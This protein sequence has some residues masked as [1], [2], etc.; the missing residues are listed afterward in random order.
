M[1]TEVQIIRLAPRFYNQR[2]RRTQH[3]FFREEDRLEHERELMRR[4]AIA[5]AQQRN[6][7]RV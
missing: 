3:C 6:L 4:D 1:R 5:R 7:R 2:Q